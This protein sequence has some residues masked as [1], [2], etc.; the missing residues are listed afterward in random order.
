MDCLVI[1]LAAANPRM[2]FIADQLD[3]LG[4]PFQRLEA[5]TPDKI[6]ELEQAYA[7][8][9][10]ERPLKET[11]KACFLSHVNAWKYAAAKDC[12]T[13]ILEDDALLSR[14]TPEVLKVIEDIGVVEHVTL[15]VRKR[16]KIVGKT[17]RQIGSAHQLLRLYQDRSGAAAYVLSPSGA[18]KLLVRASTQVALAD[19]MICKAYELKSYQI[20]PACAVQLDR[21]SAYG[22]GAI[23][24]TVSQID[25]GKLIAADKRSFGFRAR[26]IGA[27]LRMAVRALLLLRVAERREIRLNPEDFHRS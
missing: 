1:N 21:A 25:A 18:Q 19:A 11:E 9:S 8:S 23:P 14:Q 15:E 12:H 5:V 27:Q 16:K 6:G 26:R 3:A 10:W 20:E 13:L 4:I 7:W 24:S 17:G 2:A 22:I